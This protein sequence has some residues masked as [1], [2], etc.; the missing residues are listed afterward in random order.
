MGAHHAHYGW[1]E[2]HSQ[3]APSAWGGMLTWTLQTAC[4]C[5]HPHPREIHLHPN[6]REPAHG[7]P[8]QSIVL[9]L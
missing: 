5:P 1:G 7:R 9:R 8:L 6:F 2:Q 4:H 3:M